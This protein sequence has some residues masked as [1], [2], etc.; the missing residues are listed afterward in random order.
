MKTRFTSTTLLAALTV[1]GLGIA[2][3]LAD[4]GQGT[5][6]IPNTL[7]T[8]SPGVVAKPFTGSTAMAKA[9]SDASI[10]SYA[11]AAER[12][13]EYPDFRGDMPSQP[14]SKALTGTRAHGADVGTYVTETKPRYLALLT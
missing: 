3:A 7:F 10:G 9:Q 6:T 4:S 1:L 12:G 13:Y 14:V 11:T 5:I 2:P 8:E